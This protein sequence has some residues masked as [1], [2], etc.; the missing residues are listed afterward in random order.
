MEIN[1][2]AWLCTA[3]AA[4]RQEIPKKTF[5]NV[6]PEVLGAVYANSN[7]CTEKTLQDS[8]EDFHESLRELLS[9]LGNEE[10]P[11]WDGETEFFHALSHSGF[12][13][14]AFLKGETVIVDKKAF[15]AFPG[16]FSS[17][18]AA[19][20]LLFIRTDV[21]EV[22]INT[23]V[24]VIKE[25]LSQT[26]EK[27]ADFLKQNRE[28]LLL[29][30]AAKLFQLAGHEQTLPGERRELPDLLARFAE[31][32]AAYLTK[33]SSKSRYSLLQQTFSRTVEELNDRNGA[34]FITGKMNLSSRQTNSDALMNQPLHQLQW[35]KPEQLAFF[36]QPARGAQTAQ[37]IE[38]FAHI[39]AKSWFTNTKGVQRLN[40]QLVPE[41]LGRMKIELIR[42]NGEM[43]AR[44]L[45]ATGLAKELLE[46]GLPLLKHVLSQ[47]N[48]PLDKIEIF[49]QLSVPH[50]KFS[51]EEQHSQER[52]HSQRENPERGGGKGEEAE[53]FMSEFADFIISL[54]V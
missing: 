38:K 13:M 49:E 24:S 53:Y 5:G 3:S 46:S 23:I 52:H 36:N 54:E 35:S 39:M 6:F 15:S 26:P 47:Q 30:R 22:N 25:L 11:L 29:I 10:L 33:A 20:G 7:V 31:K 19:N 40:I 41:H 21:Q 28:W 17:G 44:I 37:F 4:A 32:M 42:T 12:N 14:E 16:F 45:T 34:L 48:I 43:T 51:P 9:F 18:Q 1:G 8:V 2:S 50:D 27:M